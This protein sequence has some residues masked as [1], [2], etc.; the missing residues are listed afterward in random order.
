MTD[1]NT[2]ELILKLLNDS[3]SHLIP[4][5]KSQAAKLQRRL[6]VFTKAAIDKFGSIDNVKEQGCGAV[7]SKQDIDIIKTLINV[8][9]FVT[10]PGHNKSRELTH[11]YT[12]D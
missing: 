7:E 9:S 5:R 11:F 3:I 2:G 10:I 4:Y 1:K 12:I 6:D 8:E